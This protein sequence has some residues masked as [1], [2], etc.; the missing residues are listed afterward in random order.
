MRKIIEYFK[1][2]LQ[3]VSIIEERKLELLIY[4]LVF[5]S[6]F[7]ILSTPIALLFSPLQEVISITSVALLSTL[8]LVGIKKGASYK[9]VSIGVII[10]LITLNASA[11]ILYAQFPW[12][13]AIWY[14]FYAQLSYYLISRTAGFFTIVFGV[15][16]SLIVFY[17]FEYGFIHSVE[18]KQID[19]IYLHSIALASLIFMILCSFFVF[20]FVVTNQEFVEAE[21]RDNVAKLKIK[22][23]ELEEVNKSI[24]DSLDEKQKLYIAQYRLRKIESLRRKILESVNDKESLELIIKKVVAV[25]PE[26]SQDKVGGVYWFTENDLRAGA[27]IGVE[28]KLSVDILNNC[29]SDSVKIIGSQSTFFSNITSSSDSTPMFSTLLKKNG[30]KSCWSCPI[31]NNESDLVGYFLMFDK[32]SSNKN[33]DDQYFLEEMSAM[34]SMILTSVNTEKITKEKELVEK[35]LQFKSDFLAK[36]SHELRTPLNGIIGMIDILHRNTELSDIQNSYVATLNE[37]SNDLMMIIN[38]VLD[39]SKLEAGKME[40]IKAKA[41]LKRTLQKSIDLYLPKSEDKR[42][43][44]ELFIDEKINDFQNIDSHRL[45]QVANNLISNAIKFTTKGSVQLRVKLI[46]ETEK[47]QFIR[48]SI[49]DTGSGINKTDQ[50]KLFSI[51]TQLSSSYLR[52][53]DIVTKGTGLGLVICQQL[54]KLMGGELKV[55]SEV[56]QGSEFLFELKLDKITP[57][58]KNNE[59]TT[60]KTERALNLKVLITEDKIVN[61][62]VAGLMLQ[63]MDCQVEYA[64]NGEECIDK[65]TEKPGYFDLIL[66]DIQMPIMDGITATKILK[67]DFKE[68]PPIIGLSANNMEGDASKYISMGLDDYIPKPIDSDL[69]FEKLNIFFN[70]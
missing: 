13:V 47:E 22:T 65:I 39:I 68:L 4:L 50:E 7:N 38:D 10:F 24:S 37:S 41:S 33:S 32:G 42:I 62:K 58:E 67:R 16:Y 19:P 40:I 25:I 36:M 23:D 30:L 54:I 60:E 57:H 2:D 1:P 45:R 34:T 51:Y 48:F 17:L 55:K 35:S 63:S 66:M 5:L 44:L 3:F 53:F 20:R 43:D 9:K 52:S 11:H 31:Y 28:E 18:D 49:I 26:Y 29:S 8:A 70:L 27:L 12:I 14:A 21:L 46:K 6:G 56:G 15:L 59:L 69:L 61:Q 64:N